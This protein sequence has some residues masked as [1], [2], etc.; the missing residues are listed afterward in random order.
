MLMPLLALALGL[1]GGVATADPAPPP[2]F[3]FYGAEDCPPCVAF[4]R[5]H[6]AEVEA[7][8]R[9]A[10]FNVEA[11]VIP[12]TRDVPTVGAY[13]TADDILRNAL[14]S[15]GRPYPPIFFVSRDGAILSV[16]GPDWQAA[17]SAAEA[18]VDG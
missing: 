15:G 4:K 13:G 18:A 14:D 10:G 6:L 16:H 5:S 1:L 9:R 12:R 8:G 17:K 11:Q 3:H 2:T 7:S